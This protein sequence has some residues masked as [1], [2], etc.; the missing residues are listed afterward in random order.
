MKVLCTAAIITLIMTACA[1]DTGSN[2][3]S[4]STSTAAIGTNS[5]GSKNA[6]GTDAFTT[7]EEAYDGH[8]TV[9]C[10]NTTGVEYI[11]ISPVLG[12]GMAFTP[13]LN[14]DGTLVIKK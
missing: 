2:D 5:S 3:T 8:L 13:R 11:S 9:I 12:R 1:A 14:R 7:I 10:D 6:A 4:S